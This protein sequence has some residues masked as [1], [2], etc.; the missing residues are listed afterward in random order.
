MFPPMGF[1]GSAENIAA[2]STWA[3]TW[4]VMTT[5]IPN[6]KTFLVIILSLHV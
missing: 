2:P 1:F 5:A 3:T 6:Y 4:L